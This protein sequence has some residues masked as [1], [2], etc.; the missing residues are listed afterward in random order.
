MSA[1]R[2]T[3]TDP[4][5]SRTTYE[6]QINHSDEDTFG[7]TRSVQ[8]GA[9]TL[10]TGLVKQQ[11]DDGPLTIKVRGTILHKA[12][13]VEMIAWWRLC[14]SR[15]IYF[16]DFAGDK[17]EVI[18]TSFQPTRQRTIKNP[19]DFASAPYWFWKYEL[20]MEV[21]RFIDSI[22]DGVAA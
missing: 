21:I 1:P 3:F 11:S 10:N 9:N 2:N 18:I 13:I 6:W 4:A 12:Q 17:Y 15:T 19:R 5:G 16:E 22:W 8:H 20:E 14:A 7:K